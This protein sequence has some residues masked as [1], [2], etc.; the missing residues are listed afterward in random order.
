M[1]RVFPSLT[2]LLSLW[3]LLCFPDHAYGSIDTLNPS[4]MTHD[5]L[6]LF[7]RQE[8]TD[9]SSGDT[10]TAALTSPDGSTNTADDS[11]SNLPPSSPPPPDTST[12]PE[13]TAHSEPPTS[14]ATPTIQ[15]SA[16]PPQSTSH[17]STPVTA[18]TAPA[19][20]TTDHTEH[21]SSQ[22]QAQTQTHTQ[23][24]TYST[25]ETS[26]ITPP[27]SSMDF[28]ASS[29]SSAPVESAVTSVS[30]TLVLGDMECASDPLAQQNGRCPV[31]HYCNAALKQC[32]VQ[33]NNGVTCAADFQCKSG[34]CIGTCADRT[35]FNNNSQ[36]LSGG[37]IAGI[38]LGTIGGGLVAL[39]GLL[40]CYRRRKRKM[41]AQQ[42]RAMQYMMDGEEGTEMADK[43]GAKGTTRLSKYNFLTQVLDG[44]Q[45]QRHFGFESSQQELAHT[46]P[47][48]STVNNG[49]SNSILDYQNEFFVSNASLHQPPPLFNTQS[50]SSSSTTALRPR[51]IT[52]DFMQ[53]TSYSSLPKPRP[54]S[55]AL[56]LEHRYQM[57][58]P[59]LTT[60]TTITHRDSMTDTALSSH[61]TPTMSHRFTEQQQQHFM[62][63]NTL[64]D[65]ALHHTATPTVNHRHQFQTSAPPM[66]NAQDAWSHEDQASLPSTTTTTTTT[67]PRHGYHNGTALP[68]LPSSQVPPSFF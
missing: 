65:D 61:P 39:V 59:P 3:L 68:P 48:N 57:Q 30:P 64:W 26:S 2:L 9:S 7:R 11:T 67:A 24:S 34:Y 4:L 51:P 46:S 52:D 8:T 40:F 25:P 23:Q 60:T 36:A 63:I 17:Q 32:S 10:D 13:A 42:S 54:D 29:A 22:T 33:L 56:S 21:S 1:K 50:V 55:E 6:H 19:S 12:S 31:D 43:R 53:T 20:H 66:P 16:E 58:G 5:I 27:P 62:N 47:D 37:Q 35:T 15:T 38:T 49:D 44:S 45:Q 41:A 14:S 28:T 18:T